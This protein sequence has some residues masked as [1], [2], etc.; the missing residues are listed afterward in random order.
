MDVS[1]LIEEGM[2]GF[3]HSYGMLALLS[4]FKVILLPILMPMCFKMMGVSWHFTGFYSHLETALQYRF[5]TLLRRLHALS[6]KAW[7]VLG[8][9]NEILALEEK[10]GREDRSFHQMVG[11]RDVLANCSLMDLGFLCPEFTWS[12]RQE[13]DDLVRV[14]LDR[15]LATSEWKLLFLNSS[16]RHL[17]TANSD[18]LCLLVDLAS[19][20]VLVRRKKKGR[21]FRFDNIWVREEG[22]EEAIGEAWGCS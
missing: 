22:C 20:M 4:T 17:I 8:D 18:H 15:G 21:L 19:S 14:R 11:F 9:F 10:Q 5:W 2:V 16:V 1:V 7:M 12:N 6:D 3:L 13:D